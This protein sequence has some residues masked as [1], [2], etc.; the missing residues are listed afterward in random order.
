[1]SCLVLTWVVLIALLEA[2][3]GCDGEKVVTSQWVSL[4]L[5]VYARMCVG[6]D[7]RSHLPK[8]KYRG[9]Q[10]EDK[11]VPNLRRTSDL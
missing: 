2:P 7:S 10:A 6:L 8:S 11:K 5:S 4:C 3:W 9:F 1:M